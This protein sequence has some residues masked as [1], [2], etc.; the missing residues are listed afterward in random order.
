M[1]FNIMALTGIMP[2]AFPVTST[3]T[4]LLQ[5]SLI[6]I[7]HTNTNVCGVRICTR[8]YACAANYAIYTKKYSNWNDLSLLQAHKTTSVVIY[9]ENNRT[10]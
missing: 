3:Y 6:H 1:I 10:Q 5:M 2:H 7:T 4:Q 8:T 9:K